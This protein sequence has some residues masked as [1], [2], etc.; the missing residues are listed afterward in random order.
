MEDMAAEEE[1]AEESQPLPLGVK[2]QGSTTWKRQWALQHKPLR[3][4][5]TKKRTL[6]I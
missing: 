5:Q 6:P 2:T 3:R 1:E 4:G